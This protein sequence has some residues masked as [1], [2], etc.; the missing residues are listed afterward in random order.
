LGGA[1]TTAIIFDDD[2]VAVPGTGI[3]ARESRDGRSKE[4]PLAIGSRRGE[5]R[6]GPRR[7]PGGR[8]RTKLDAYCE[9]PIGMNFVT[10]ALIHFWRQP[11]ALALIHFWMQ[12]A[13]LHGSKGD[14]VRPHPEEAKSKNS[15][16]SWDPPHRSR[17]IAGPTTRPTRI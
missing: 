15:T 10:L 7:L 9:A 2:V 13:S 12:P 1:A 8:L 14:P 16:T 4:E 11:A 5:G 6:G 17:R 3:V